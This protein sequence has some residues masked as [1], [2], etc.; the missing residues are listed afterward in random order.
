VPRSHTRRLGVFV[1]HTAVA[2][3]WLDLVWP[4]FL[5]TGLEDVRID[6]GITAFTPLDFTYDPWTHSL[7]MALVWSV[8]VGAG[9]AI[10]VRRAAGWM[11]VGG[12]T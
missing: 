10:V 4:I 7:V 12:R 5:L 9:S 2:L 6:P 3:V 1:G 8:A 11:L